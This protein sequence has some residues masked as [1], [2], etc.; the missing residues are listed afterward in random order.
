MDK[1]SQSLL[2]IFYRNPIAGKV[3]TRLAATI[4]EARTLKIYQ[5]LSRHTHTITEHLSLDKI[6]YYSDFVTANDI[7]PEEVFQKALQ[8]GDTLG[9]KMV[10]AFEEGFKGGYRHI[11]IIGTDCYELTAEIIDEVFASLQTVDAVIG[12]ARDGGYY[13]LGMNKLM[14]QVFENK[15]WST[16]SVFQDTV[17]DFESLALQYVTLPVLRDVDRDE[18]IPEALK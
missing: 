10:H 5:E 6:V 13:L 1:T 18:D 15:N 4:G 12:P 14:S 9:Q 7:W 8:H 3:K 16:E 17:R 2:I 11:C